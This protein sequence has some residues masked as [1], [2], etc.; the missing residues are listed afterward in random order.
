MYLYCEP[1]GLSHK[2][3][4]MRDAAQ[5]AIAFIDGEAQIVTKSGIKTRC[6]LDIL[7]RP[8]TQKKARREQKA[9]A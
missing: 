9:A 5:I 1:C 6:L 7:G 4:L 3:L 8:P 2:E